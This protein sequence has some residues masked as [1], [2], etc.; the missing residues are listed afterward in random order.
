MKYYQA[1]DNEK[2]RFGDPYLKKWKYYFY[3]SFIILKFVI[4]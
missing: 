1:N 4:Y 3:L 2:K